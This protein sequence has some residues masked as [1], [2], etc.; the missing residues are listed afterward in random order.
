M[1]AHI[2]IVDDEPDILESLE[3]VLTSSGYRVSN[4]LDAKT[5]L[6]ILEYTKIDVVVTD[7]RM[8]GLDGIRFLKHAKQ[9]DPE[10]K[11]IILTGYATTTKA[12]KRLIQ[13]GAAEILMKPLESVSQLLQAV[14]NTLP[15]KTPAQQPRR[16][17][18]K[19]R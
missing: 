8:P 7:I 11:V 1:K 9:T 12:I 6:S 2:L 10:L 19:R 5:A 16:F 3:L 13:N 18:P 14:E 4:V 15:K 17:S